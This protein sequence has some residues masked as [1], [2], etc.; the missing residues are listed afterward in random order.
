MTFKNYLKLIL[1]II[2]IQNFLFFGI[3]K[4]NSLYSEN[5]IESLTGEYLRKQ[6]K[7]SFYIFGPGDKIFLEVNEKSKELNGIF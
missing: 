7:E 6:R 2:L 5:N 3:I 4:T 1:K